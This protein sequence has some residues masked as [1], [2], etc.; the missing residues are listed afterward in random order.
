[1]SLIN[2]KIHANRY[3]SE[4]GGE[5]ICFSGMKKFTFFLEKTIN[6][7]NSKYKQTQF[8]PLISRVGEKFLD[9]L[10]RPSSSAVSL[11]LFF[12]LLPFTCLCVCSFISFYPSTSFFPIS[13]SQ[14][15][16]IH[17]SLP[18]S[19]PFTFSFSISHSYLT[20]SL[21]V[22]RSFYLSPSLSISL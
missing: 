5:E 16:R 14:H 6:R 19:L 20:L 9:T 13:L 3:S 17:V 22:Y 21:S 18:L 7:K 11:V 12:F 1:M 2:R 10:N 15:Y 4:K 8:T